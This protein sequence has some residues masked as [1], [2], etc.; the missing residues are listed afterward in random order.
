MPFDAVRTRALS[1]EIVG[2]VR[3][4]AVIVMTRSSYGTWGERPTESI[5]RA[6]S[7]SIHTA[8]ATPGAILDANLLTGDRQT[9]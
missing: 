2:S 6:E 7:A 9:D 5:D 1:R 3:R 4:V 8:K